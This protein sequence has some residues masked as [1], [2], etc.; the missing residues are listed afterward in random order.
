MLKRLTYLILIMGLIGCAN[1]ILNPLATPQ[2]TIS[3]RTFKIF[4]GIPA[5]LS[6]E[7][8]AVRLDDTWMITAAHNR[9]IIFYRD[10]LVYHPDCDIALFKDPTNKPVKD[11][12]IEEPK[13]DT[14]LSAAGYP[15]NYPLVED[16]GTHLINVIFPNYPD[17]IKALGSYGTMKGMSGGGVWGENGALMGIIHGWTS[18]VIE[19][20]EGGSIYVPL[21]PIKD[22]LMEQTGKDY[23]K[24]NN[25]EETQQT[26]A[27]TSDYNSTIGHI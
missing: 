26:R 22:W 15:L 20:H 24:G 19:T 8:S 11:L 18:E 17:C 7:G 9:P 3:D 21:Y 1:K 27:I 23:T 16:A 10:G 4:L 6:L 13:Y 12:I 5:F 14:K 25:P 2:I